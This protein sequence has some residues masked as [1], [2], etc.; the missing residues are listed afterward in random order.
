MTSRSAAVSRSNGVLALV[1]AMLVLV[2][3]NPTS[4][5]ELP[6]TADVPGG[7]AVVRLDSSA[8]EVRVAGRVQPVVMSAQGP[9]ALVGIPLSAKGHVDIDID[10]ATRRLT[11][12]DHT[13][14]V[15]HIRVANKDY[16]S[17]NAEQLARYRRERAAMDAVIERVSAAPQ[18]IFDWP[19][20]VAGKRSDS[21]G[22]RRVFNG[23]PRNPHSGMDLAAAHGT[24]VM[25]PAAA[26]VALVD[27]LFF[28]GTTVM[29]DH[30]RGIVTL[31]CHLSA[32]NVNVG[33]RVATGDVLG[34]VGASG[35]VT[36]PHLHFS[37]YI[38]GSAVNPALLL[39]PP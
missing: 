14:R 1:L 20:P 31:Y 6:R 23:Q 29:L 37:A 26:T 15:Q 24:D 9:V 8:A 27:D 2:Q 21:F 22:A 36:G 16:V 34:A 38:G 32:A 33:D 28:N 11:L 7:L 39:A 5:N 4:A 18:P 12:S 3:A 25:A 30:G 17:P 10:G 13:Y 19:A 35:R